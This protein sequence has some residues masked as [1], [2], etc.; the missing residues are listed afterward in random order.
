MLLHAEGV[1]GAEPGS[2]QELSSGL[3]LLAYASIALPVQVSEQGQASQPQR[4]QAAAQPQPQPRPAPRQPQQEPW[5]QP[6]ALAQPQPQ[7]RPQPGALAHPQ[8]EPGQERQP[9]PVSARGQLGARYTLLD[10]AAT[11]CTALLTCHLPSC[12]PAPSCPRTSVQLSR[13]GS[14]RQPLTAAP[15]RLAARLHRRRCH[16]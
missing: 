2:T 1:E 13:P 14:L 12:P 6:S 11:P 5:A 8:Q 15:L 16:G 4:R 7:P 9:Q 10:R 3:R